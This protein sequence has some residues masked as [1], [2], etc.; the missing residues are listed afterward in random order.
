MKDEVMRRLVAKYDLL[1]KGCLA[2]LKLLKNRIQSGSVKIKLF[3][4]KTLQ[5]RQNTLFKSNQLQVYKELSGKTK[6]DNP[7]P[8]AAA[9]KAF[10]SGIWSEEMVHNGEAKWL[11]DVKEEMKEKVRGMADIVVKIEDVVKKIKGMFNWKVPGLDGEQGYWFKA[12]DCLH[13]PI[14]NALQK[15][16]VEGDVPEWMVSGRTM[17]IQKDPTKGTKASN[18]RP[19]ACLPLIWKLLS[20]IFADR[21]YAH[22]LDNQLLPEEQKGAKKKLRGTKDQLLID[23]TILKEVKRLKKNVVISWTHYK[24]AYDMVPHS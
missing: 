9:A 14:V 2:I 8:D 20:G 1:E 6:T 23:K 21:V 24:K 7:S 17:S 16:V 11:V 13:E 18:Y 22:L 3:T 4:E 5:H 15:C 19:I 10:W 12:F